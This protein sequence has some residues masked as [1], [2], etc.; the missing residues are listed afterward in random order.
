MITNEC[1]S[2]LGWLLDGWMDGLMFTCFPSLSLY[3][4]SMHGMHMSCHHRL[5][6]MSY[7]W[8]MTSMLLIW[9]CMYGIYI[10][11]KYNDR[12]YIKLIEELI[13]MVHTWCLIYKVISSSLT[14]VTWYIIWI[15]CYIVTQLLHDT[16]YSYTYHTLTE[17][18]TWFFGTVL[19]FNFSWCV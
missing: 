11:H 2:L 12:N 19:D 7:V 10:R 4:C 1:I 8:Y 18:K 5:A 9:V 13:L 6:H 14:N 15:C 3:R 16:V 17:V